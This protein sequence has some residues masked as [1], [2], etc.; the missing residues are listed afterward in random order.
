MKDAVG[1]GA[2]LGFL[3][4]MCLIFW[5]TAVALLPGA[6]N[7]S[8]VVGGPLLTFPAAWLGRTLLDRHPSPESAARTTLLVHAAVGVTLLVPLIRAIATHREWAG[9]PL[10]VPDAIGLALVLVTGAALLLVVVNLALRGLGAPFAVALS[11]RLATDWLYA[12]TRNPM[13]LAAFAFLVSMGIRFRSA[14][15]VLWVL[16]LF[17]PALLFFVRVYE[18]RELEI[19][20][21]EPYRRYRDATPFLWPSRRLRAPPR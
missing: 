11:R 8:V 10:P 20:F 7:M 14:P 3:A 16:L 9:W 21:G 2:R 17:A 6:A 12:W 13:A 18:E 1:P 19:R 4:L 15:F 5:Q